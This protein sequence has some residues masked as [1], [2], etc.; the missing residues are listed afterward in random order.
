MVA[1]DIL[2][3]SGFGVNTYILSDENGD[4]IIVDPACHSKK[5]KQEL[6]DFIEKDE[7]TPLKIINTHTHVDHI[8]GN[9]FLADKYNLVPESHKNGQLFL[10]IAVE[11][12]YRF[13]MVVD[14][15]PKKVKFIDE[16]NKIKAGNIELEVLYTPGHADGSICLLSRD[17]KFVIA[18][19][20]LFNGSIGRTD[21]LTGNMEVLRD[22]IKTKLFTLPDDFIVYPGH[23]PETTIGSEK[24]NNPFLKD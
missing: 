24:L 8:L 6:I 19:D 9:R 5:E 10:E 17:E 13:G 18:G 11:M 16:K 23:G 3:F 4:C 7:L 20:V 15:P 22:S 21:L 14:D 2:V 12:G 1:I